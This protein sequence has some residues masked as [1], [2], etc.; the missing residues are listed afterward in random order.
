MTR[1]LDYMSWHKQCLSSIRWWHELRSRKSNTR[2][3]YILTL[4]GLIWWYKSNTDDEKGMCYINS[5]FIFSRPFYLS[6][7]WHDMV[8]SSSDDRHDLGCVYVAGKSM[9]HSLP[10]KLE[11]LSM[12]VK[13]CSRTFCS[14][15]LRL[16]LFPTRC[17]NHSDMIVLQ[18]DLINASR[19]VE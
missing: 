10:N 5:C 17:H 13:P 6:M 18:H 9:P 1:T 16:C 15:V 3:L 7:Q 4:W 12:S 11:T 14:H 19:V 2:S 8:P